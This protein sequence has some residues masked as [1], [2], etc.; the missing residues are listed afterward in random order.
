MENEP[1]LSDEMLEAIRIIRSDKRSADF[2][3][4]KASHQQ[5]IERLDREAEERKN[6]APKEE[7]TTDPPKAPGS[8][9]GK[10]PVPVLPPDA[11][12]PPAKIEPVPEVEKKTRRAWYERDNYRHD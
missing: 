4:L 6:N 9:R 2:E 7:T 5:L 8:E 10:P 1:E 11:P 3:E 12:L